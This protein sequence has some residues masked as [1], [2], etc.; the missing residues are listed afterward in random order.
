[1]IV[2][3]G[4]TLKHWVNENYLRALNRREIHIYD[5]DVPA[6]AEA[7]DAVNARGNGCW[8]AQTLKHEV[9]SYLHPDAI[10]D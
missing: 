6:Y 4:G 3:G 8:A 10:H 9:E 7:V 1:F 2:L 5:R